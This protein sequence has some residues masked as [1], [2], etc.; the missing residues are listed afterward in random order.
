MAVSNAKKKANAKWDNENMATLAC[1]V[2]KEQAERFR[3]HCS[4]MGETV[5]AVLQGYVQ[6]C[7]GANPAEAPET[8]TGAPQGVGAIL[9]PSA[10]KTAQE[11]A[12]KA[13]ETV[14]AFV[15]RAVETQAKRDKL[16]FA[17]RPKEKAQ[18]ESG[19]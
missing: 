17:I 3:L 18:D 15:E 11:A 4:A 2:K 10:L 13:G 16:T 5:N 6:S 7:V 12:E 19:T 14:P 8:P 9:T 1:K